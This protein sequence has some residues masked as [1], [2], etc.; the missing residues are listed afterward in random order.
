MIDRYTHVIL[1]YLEGINKTSSETLQDLFDQYSF[2]LF[3]SNAG[4]RRDLYSRDPAEVRLT[5]FFGGVT[6]VE[7]Q[8]ASSRELSSERSSQQQQG[9]RK[10]RSSATVL[11]GR[12]KTL[13][14]SAE[15]PALL[16]KARD[17]GLSMAS[18]VSLSLVAVHLALWIHLRR[19]AKSSAVEV[20]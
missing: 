12:R 15:T 1:N 13:V 6:P 2:D 7:L 20:R 18:V 11:G 4:I 10:R 16:E 17:S 14:P 9:R 8:S 19:Q 3:H 5:A